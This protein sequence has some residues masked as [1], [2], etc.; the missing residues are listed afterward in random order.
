MT[1]TE[2]IKAMVGENNAAMFTRYF[3]GQLWY[4]VSYFDEEQYIAQGWQNG[5]VN[6]EFPVPIADIGNATFHHREKALLLMRYI[7]KHLEM[8]E[9]AQA[10]QR[11]DSFSE[12]PAKTTTSEES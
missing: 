7:R 9:K 11:N 2:K 8:L 5:W 3:D 1:K 10:D 4:A 12:S 6:F